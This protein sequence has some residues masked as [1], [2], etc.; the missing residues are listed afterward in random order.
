MVKAALQYYHTWSSENHA[1]MVGLPISILAN[2]TKLTKLD[3]WSDTCYM[4]LL[5][6]NSI[7]TLLLRY[8]P[9]FRRYCNS[10]ETYIVTHVV[11]ELAQSHMSKFRGAGPT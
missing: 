11:F 3:H 4:M 8:I 6:R 7:R 5:I 2:A 1:Q 10:Y 9:T